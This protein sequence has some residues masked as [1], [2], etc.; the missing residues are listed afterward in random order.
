MK[1]TLLKTGDV[2]KV[3]T[4]KDKGKSGK[5]LQVFP[6]LQRAVVEGVNPSKRHLRSRQSGQKGQVVEFFMPLH[7]SNLQLV[8]AAGKAL[9]HDDR[10]KA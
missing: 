1:T 5:I 2:V 7:V 9:R 10:P 6:R 8:D 3:T 4:G